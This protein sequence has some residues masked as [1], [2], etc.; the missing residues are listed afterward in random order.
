M[1][2]INVNQAN[3]SETAKGIVEEATQVEVN[4]GTDTGATGAK[5]F[6]VP[7]KYLAGILLKVLTGFVAGANLAVVATDTL[8]QALAKFQGQINGEITART[9]AD[10]NETNARIAADAL[11]TPMTRT[12]S[13][14]APLSGG[15]DLSANRTLTTS[16]NTARLIGRN[17][18][19]VGVME[20]ITLGT[21]LSFTGTILNAT[22]PF[23][24]MVNATNSVS[25][26][27]TTSAW[28]DTGLT[29]T[30]TPSSASSKI[31]IAVNM[32]GCYKDTNDTCI[33]LRL[34]R[35][36]ATVVAGIEGS[37]GRTASGATNGIGGNGGTFEDSP[38]TVAATTYKVQFASNRNA[39]NVYINGSDS[40]FVS[41]SSMTLIEYLP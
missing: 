41:T 32:Q 38:A 16:M 27:S 22:S 7:S 39:A 8:A 11:L 37:S 18:A 30:I 25:A 5:L 31:L 13:T 34:L 3:A 9:N 2:I 19:G 15:G 14:T 36:A 35:D 6:V 28:A 12:I 1:P 26:T 17:T 20:E 21:N 24:Q 4:A 40:G 10:T 23:K 29:A 33:V